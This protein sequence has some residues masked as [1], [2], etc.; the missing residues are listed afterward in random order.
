MRDRLEFPARS[1]E[2]VVKRSQ[3]DDDGR[4]LDLWRFQEGFGEPVGCISTTYTFDG[5]F[6]EEQCLSRFVGME[7]DPSED[8]R[9]YL[10]EREQKFSEVFAAV[11]VDRRNVTSKRSL[12][13]HQLP[14]AVPS[15]GILHAKLTLLA[16]TDHVRVLIGSANLTKPGYRS[17]YEQLARL[18]FGPEESTATSLLMDV[19]A[20]IRQI[21]RFLPLSTGPVDRL[22]AFLSSV[23]K[24]AR[25]WTDV[26]WRAGETRAVLMPIL[27][28]SRS[29]FQQ[30]A[31]EWRG[32]GGSLATITSPFFDNDGRA[33]KVIEKL[34]DVLAVNGER[35]ISFETSGRKL[36]TER[37]IELDLPHVYETSWLKR[38][39]HRF[40]YAEQQDED[41]NARALHAKSIRLER[42]DYSMFIVGSSNFTSAGTG[43][44][45]NCNIEVNLAYVIPPA[46]SRFWRSCLEAVP[47][48]VKIL[49]EKI[50][51][52]TPP[53]KTADSDLTTALLPISFGE[54]LFDPS[55]AGGVLL[56][57]F[58]DDA[59]FVT[60][61]D[62]DGDSLEIAHTVPWKKLKPPSYLLVSWREGNKTRDSIWVVN[63]TDASK[64][65][66]PD[67]LRD[68][69]LEVLVEVLSSTRPLY[70]SVV[71]ALDRQANK[72]SYDR[73]I[74][75]DPLRRVDTSSFLLKNVQRVSHALEGLRERLEKPALT[76]DSLRW[77]L[78]GPIGPLALARRLIAEAE[79]SAAFM[80]AEIAL[81]ISGVSWQQTERLLGKDN[82]RSE[83]KEVT[84]ELR[85]M[86]EDRMG[87][88]DVGRYA[89]RTFQEIGP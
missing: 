71:R 88:G 62:E 61:R 60:L 44:E 84:N 14:V 1:K 74:E 28:R 53:D 8:L 59:P 65:P 19:V 68:L 2:V 20:A 9:S 54:A 33:R 87:S 76:L 13:W 27:P 73:S 69:S 32:T 64:L 57:S 77:R 70:E 36:P 10:I 47:P 7:T 66:P 67:E 16:W 26:S 22:A 83:I 79:L 85:S 23:E 5:P 39:E 72:P 42:N 17:N 35:T 52:R 82:V 48:T 50:R 29:L 18:D 63:V 15:G 21:A 89:K 4:L 58:Q 30:I 37:V 31:D 38:V 11:L 81:T 80:I 41:G 34:V 86:L 78:R 56:L 45:P 24:K 46:D 75:L 12:R 40:A 43:I 25:S 49:N 3:S 55:P 51:F 6:F